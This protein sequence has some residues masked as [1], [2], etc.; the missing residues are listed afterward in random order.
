MN[1][2]YDFIIAGAGSAGCVLANRLSADPKN[3]VLLLEAG[4][5]DINPL[6]HIP[7]ALALTHGRKM[8]NWHY[9]SEPDANLGGREIYMPRGKTLGGSSSINGMVYIRG[10]GRDYDLWR[11]QGCTGWS[12]EDVLPYFRRS[13]RNTEILDQ[14]HGEDGL[15]D[16]QRG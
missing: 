13:E 6:I 16:V 5:R 7:L 8:N 15:L 10:H 11:Q 14:F 3:R 1:Q 12:Y 4:G 2:E 9:H